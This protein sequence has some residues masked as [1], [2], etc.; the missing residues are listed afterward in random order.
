M[1]DNYVEKYLDIVVSDDNTII[2]YC[3]QDNVCFI[4]DYPIGLR[5]IT[6]ELVSEIVMSDWING[7]IH[8][9]AN[10]SW[11]DRVPTFIYLATP[12]YGSVFE[13]KLKDKETYSQFFIENTNLGRGIHVIIKKIDYNLF[14]SKFLSSSIEKEEDDLEA[15]NKSYERY[16]KTISQFKI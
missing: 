16:T 4:Y 5:K 13:K 9:L 15:K 2:K 10:I 7:V 12:I 1:Q 3:N 14:N 11:N 8:T 6:E